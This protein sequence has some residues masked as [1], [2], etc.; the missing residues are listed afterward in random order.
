MMNE[1]KTLTAL[2][3]F[4]K[5]KVRFDLMPLE[6]TSSLPIPLKINEKIYMKLLFYTGRKF[7][8]EE[9]VKI[10]RPN[11]EI[12][13]DYSTARIVS[14]KN[15]RS[16]FVN[17]DWYKPIGE[18]PHKKIEKL[19]VKEYKQENNKLLDEYDKAVDLFLNNSDDDE[20]KRNFGE[21]FHRLC[22]PCLLPFM[23]KA[24]KDFFDWLELDGDS[25]EQEIEIN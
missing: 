21:K 20:F 25:G 23:V 19:T 14:Y 17:L 11:C 15:Y 12:V 16:L 6:S 13:L 2:N 10:F 24:G 3:K 8:K 4:R 22:A 7:K 1:N 9:K 18:F 5:S